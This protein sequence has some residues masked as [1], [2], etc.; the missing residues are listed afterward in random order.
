MLLD[1]LN[2]LKAKLHSKSQNQAENKTKPDTS[3]EKDAGIVFNLFDDLDFDD[4]QQDNRVR[5]S[6]L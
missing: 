3:I 4:L 2:Q 5:T 1:H 6:L